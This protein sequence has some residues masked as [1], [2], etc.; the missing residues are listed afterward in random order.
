MGSAQRGPLHTS[1]PRWGAGK[2]QKVMNRSVTIDTPRAYHVL[3]DSDRP[4]GTRRKSPSATLQASHSAGH[5]RASRSVALPYSA[6]SE[7]DLRRNA[8]SVFAANARPGVSHRYTFVSTAQVIDLLCSEGWE[9]VLA[10]QQRVRL[11]ERQ[12]FQMHEVRF[13][14]RDYLDQ[15]IFEVGDVRPELIL[16]NA[17]DGTRAYRIDAGLYRL[18]CRN[19]LVVADANFAHVAIRHF[20]V[21]AEKFATAAQ[22]VVESTPRVLETVARW[23]S[24]RLTE[25]AQ[26][27][28][29]GRAAALRWNPE[30]PVG[31]ALT[32]EKL[33]RP[34][35]VGDAGTDLWTTFNLCQEHLLLGGDRYVA[36]IIGSPLRENTTRPVGDLIQAARLNK[37]LWQVARDAAKKEREASCLNRH[38][39]DGAVPVRPDRLTAEGNRPRF[40]GEG[41]SPHANAAAAN[42]TA[43]NRATSNRVAPKRAPS[44]ISIKRVYAPPAPSDGR[45]FLAER[46]WPR[47]I[48]KEALLLDGWPR[49]AA[50]STALRQWFGH[51]PPAGW[52]FNAATMP[53]SKRIRTRG[54]QFS[55]RRKPVPSRCSSLPATPST[56]T[57]S[58]CAR[59]SS[60]G[61]NGN[62]AADECALVLAA[63]MI[64]ARGWQRLR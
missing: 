48:K 13:T 2:Q 5:L 42:H 14:R 44:S 33:L 56:T 37:T 63:G 35:R 23:Q 19:G 25:L 15:C 22:A 16:Q 41:T 58:R 45:R 3:C 52:N 17:H 55:Q 43:S 27:E 21:S 46:L 54:S 20:D 32:P 10:R 31:R 61:R 8:P 1:A 12:G 11:P 62:R 9:P 50:P 47:G 24:V 28:F 36:V 18:V 51:D 34:R 53:N 38:L 6:L 64:S 26:H 49:D 57:S 4:Q 29:A 39:R 30:Q 59:F 7:E 40:A 60:R